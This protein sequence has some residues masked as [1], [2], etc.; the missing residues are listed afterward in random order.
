MFCLNKYSL[1]NGPGPFV[2]LREP[3]E[4]LSEI[5]IIFFLCVTVWDCSAPGA[6]VVFER[7]IYYINGP[8]PFG[9]GSRC[10]FELN[11]HL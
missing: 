3:G 9:S 7:D 1:M 4:V 11:I 2:W 8:G 10:R 5:I 6:G